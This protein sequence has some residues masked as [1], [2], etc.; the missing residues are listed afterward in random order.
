[1]KLESKD[2]ESC[3]VEKFTK[4]LNEKLTIVIGMYI[5]TLSSISKFTFCTSN[6]PIYKSIVRFFCKK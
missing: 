1:M 4:T 6:A 3:L 2:F 5:F